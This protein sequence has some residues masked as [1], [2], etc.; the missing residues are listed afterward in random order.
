MKNWEYQYT[1]KKKKK[2]K[3]K[4]KMSMFSSQILDSVRF[5]FSKF[6]YFLPTD[7]HFEIIFFSS[8]FPMIIIIIYIGG[9]CNGNFAIR[10]KKTDRNFF[11]LFLIDWFILNDCHFEFLNFFF[12]CCFFPSFLLLLLLL[13]LN[14]HLFSSS[15]FS[16]IIIIIGFPSVVVDDDDRFLFRFDQ[17]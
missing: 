7:I 16:I 8:T 3:G 12:C 1:K 2:M 6:S 9:S 17:W 15:G 11:F 4:P 10:I 13:S 14:F 5:F